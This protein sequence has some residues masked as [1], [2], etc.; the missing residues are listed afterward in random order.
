MRV[1]QQSSPHTRR[2]QDTGDIMRLVI[3]ASVPGMLAL[4]Y[5]FGSGVLINVVIATISC[6]SAEAAIL[7]LRNRPV[8]TYLQDY[9]A[10]VTAVLLGLA[11]PPLV[12]WWVVV[13]AS[14]FSIVVAKQLYGGLGSNPFNPAMVG[15]VVVLISFPIEMTTWVT[16]LALLPEGTYHPS[17]WQ[18]IAIVFG[19]ATPV[20][21]ITGA[22]PLD[23]FKHNDGLL[24]SQIYADH[25]LFNQASFAGVGWEWANV[26]FLIGGVALMKKGVFTWHAPG[27]MLLS[28]ALMSLL[29]WDGGSSES[30]GSP[31][32]HL[33]SGATMLGAFFIITD[34]VSSATSQRGRLVY[35]ALIGVLIYVIR[36]WGDY[37]DAL[38]FAI[39]L[40]NLCAPLIDRYTIPQ[41]YGQVNTVKLEEN[42]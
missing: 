2:R 10:V 6:I 21:G 23:L 30:P 28:L 7:S 18:S 39:L 9:S 42:E 19:H 8:Q 13:V 31:V 12:S 15:Y 17:L 38:A 22:T 37:P 14:V 25:S 24:V 26:A 20:D 32:L 40:G 4:T 34:P 35:G 29:F 11:L 1:S 27:A 41:P 36:A 33:F 3:L 16:P 5:H